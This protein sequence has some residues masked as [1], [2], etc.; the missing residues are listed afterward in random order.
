MNPEFQ[1]NLW[2]EL[3]PRRLILMTALLALAFLAAGLA[4]NRDTAVLVPVAATAE[5][6]YYAIVVVWGTRN[7]ALAVVGEIRD[8]TWDMQ[9]LSSIEPLAMTWAKLFGSTIYNWFGGAL[10]LVVLLGETA[11]HQ[12][13][14]TALI[15]LV[16]YIAVGVIAQAAAFLA[17]LIAVRRRQSH[18]RLDTF[19]Y[20]AA[21]LAAGLA[22]YSV[23]QAA[24]PANFHIAHPADTDTVLWW[25]AKLDAR[26]FL[27]VSLALFAAWIL[28]G[29]YRQM[30]LELQMQNGTLVW[31]GFLL[32]IGLYVSG[33]D[34]WLTDN[35]AMARLGAVS[36]RLG[37]AATT[38]AA[39]TYVMVFLEPKDRVHYRWLGSQI[40]ASRLGAAWNGLEAWMMAY[41]AAAL[42][43]VLLLVWL[44][45]FEA[46]VTD[47]PA[48]IAAALGFVTRDVSIFVFMRTLPGRR[49]GDLAALGVL[50]ALY[51]LAPAIANG[52][53]LTAILTIFYPQDATP[54][55]IAPLIAWAEGLAAATFAISRI[56]LV[57]PAVS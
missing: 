21:G 52:L 10:C 20:Q 48:L 44:P 22:V 43:A 53:G 14:A 7:A 51:V 5:W 50:F 47:Q 26:G 30:R 37:L 4:T 15:D 28:T 33:F 23:W 49:R 6:L 3:T 35:G 12:D 42:C 57:K 46:R 18:S 27:L 54:L 13:V 32:F 29:C 56:A 8:R 45:G 34:A 9:L 55:W 17:S 2:L 40:A 24:D 16:Y 11:V 38:Y 41:L 31:L 36:L 19:L 1:R 25:G 39:L